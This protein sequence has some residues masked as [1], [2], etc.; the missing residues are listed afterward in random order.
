LI[1]ILLPAKN[2]S[3]T[4][5]TSIRS[6]LVSAPKK[7]EIL[8]MDDG[9]TDDTWAIINRFAVKD[10]RVR[11]FR[12]E[13]SHGV[14]TS[15]NQ[16][17]AHA[18]GEYLVRMDADDIS[19]PWRL[20]M[21]INALKA[22]KADFIF[23]PAIRFGSS[24]FRPQRPL[25]LNN[26]EAKIELMFFNPFVH[27][28]MACKAQSLRSLYGYLPASAEDYDLWLRAS[29]AGFS[30]SRLAVPSLFYRVHPRQVTA[31][32]KWIQA[33]KDDPILIASKEKFMAK[34]LDELNLSVSPEI[35]GPILANNLESQERLLGI[36]Q[37]A[38]FG[39]AVRR[40]VYADIRRSIEV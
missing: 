3:K 20:P 25:S 15:L 33:R 5:K 4:I 17:L 40:R 7:S 37:R 35:T 13:E 23:T 22:G 24:G 19:T 11:V 16:L 9:S 34:V 28:A 14:A 26:L 36:L 29:A 6:V 38:K 10:S 2:A 8:I 12:N 21:Q 1:S 32:P 39:S 31:D 18:E 27:S 30:L